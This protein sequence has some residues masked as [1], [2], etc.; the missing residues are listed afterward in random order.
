MSKIVLTAEQRKT[1]S[2][3]ERNFHQVVEA[4]FSSA[5][6]AGDVDTLLQAWRDITGKERSG[7]RNGCNECVFHLLED[8]AVMYLADVPE[9]AAPAPGDSPAKPSGEPLQPAKPVKAT[10]TPAKKKNAPKRK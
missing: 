7:F 6:G 5:L 10:T 2:R 1:L 3:Y 8:L 9:K 4:R